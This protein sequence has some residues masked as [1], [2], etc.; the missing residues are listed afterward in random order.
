MEKH[1]LMLEARVHTQHSMERGDTA[2]PSRSGADPA[3]AAGDRHQCP[4][5]FATTA[6][7]QAPSAVWHPPQPQLPS[8]QPPPAPCSAGTDLP[9]AALLA[10]ALGKDGDRVSCPHRQLQQFNIRTGLISVEYRHHLSRGAN[11]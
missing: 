4:S 7:V 2:V 10:A 8:S 5:R 9:G 11:A 1:L 6:A 3:A